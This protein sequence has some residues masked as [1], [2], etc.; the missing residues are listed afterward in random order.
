MKTR[1]MILALAV[2]SLSSYD[3]NAQIDVTLNTLG[4]LVSGTQVGVDLVIS[5]DFSVEGSIGYNSN[6]DDDRSQKYTSVPIQ[7]LGKYYFNPDD[8]ADKFY[9]GGFLRYVNRSYK[10]EGTSSFADLTQSR[11]GVGVGLGYKIVSRKNIVFDFGTT[12]GTVVSDNTKYEDS[13][14]IQEEISIPGIIVG[15]KIG[16]GYRFGG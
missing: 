15:F 8:G 6:T 12:F 2:F 16:I 14:G 9:V 11:F 4:I 7:F 13:D 10:A 5:P 3:A 1:L